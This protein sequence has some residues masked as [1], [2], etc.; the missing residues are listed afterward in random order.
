MT[1]RKR[2]LKRGLFGAAVAAALLA[3]AAAEAAAVSVYPT[4][5][6]IDSRTRTAT[7]TLTNDGLRAEEIEISF[8]FGMPVADEF[9]LVRVAFMDSVGSTVPSV[10]PYIRAF[11]QRMRL[12]PGQTQVVRL[13]VQPPAGLPDG[14]YWGRVMVAS[15]GGQAPVEQRQGDITMQINIRT[16]IAIGVYYRSG[17]VETSLA[18]ENARA[19][20]EEGRAQLFLSLDRGGNAATIGRVVAELV[21]PQGTV[22]AEHTESI[23]VHQDM[24]W[25]VDIPLPA[26][27][28]APGP[29][30]TVRY[31]IE[32]RRDD[33]DTQLLRVEPI[34]G[35]VP[36]P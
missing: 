17:Q 18:V 4:A 14:E 23:A 15:V 25:R 21:D 10:V 2:A 30:Y 22:V 20:L 34:R 1:K 9:G 33:L 27:M 8:A 3:G 12:E 26:D 32:A 6:F 16:V 28:P 35:V 13:L 31:L 29:G 11:P 19:S 7:L 5:V 36:I 24:L